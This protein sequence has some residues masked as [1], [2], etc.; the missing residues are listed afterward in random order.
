MDEELS[1]HISADALAVIRAMRQTQDSVDQL[2]LQTAKRFGDMQRAGQSLA[3]M[4]GGL[5]AGVSIGAVVGKLVGVQREFDVLNSSMVTITGSSA[6][7]EQEMR[8]IKEFAAT[9]PFALTEVTQAFVKMKSLGLDAS[10]QSLESY[11][12]TAS[13]MGKNLNQLIEAVADASTGEFERLKEFGIKANTEGNKVSLTFQGVTTTIGKNAAE[14]TGYLQ[15]LG[16]NQFAGAM[17]TRAATLDGAI[18]NLGDT[19]DELF[20][21]VNK[22]NA[23]TLIA[24]SVKLASGALGDA[25]VVL[26]ALNAATVQNA[27]DTGALSTFQ[28]ALG[29]AFETV[30][31]LGLELK[32]VLVQ[33]GRELGALAAQAVAVATLDF[34]QAREIGRLAR[35]DAAQARKDLDVATRNVLMAR[36]RAEELKAVGDAGD[37]VSRRAASAASAAARQ[38]AAA[39]AAAAKAAEAAA[40]AAKNAVKELEEQRKLIAELNGLQ[41]DYLEQLARHAALRAKGA[42]SETEYVKALE[43]LIAK[44]PSS[45]ALTKQQADLEKDRVEALKALAEMERKRTE[46][47]E[48]T[49][50]GLAEQNQ[51][52]REEIELIGLTERAQLSVIQARMDAVILTKE[53]TLAELERASAITGSQTRIEIALAEEIR[54]LRERGELLSQK[55]SRTE[56][57]KVY[58]DLQAEGRRFMEQLEQGL[59]DSLFRAF[60]AGRGFF[61][62][63]WDGI[64]N[65]FKTTVL[66]LAIQGVVGSVLGATGL[67]TAN[68]ASASSGLEGQAVN[69]LISQG[70]QSLLGNVTIAGSSLAAI[71]SSV[72]TG[73]SAGFSGTSVTAAIAAY[74]EAGMAGVASGLGLGASLGTALSTVAMAIPYVA[75]A[76]AVLSAIGAFRSTKQVGYGIAGTLGEGD[77]NDYALNRKSGT[78]F[79]G[80]DYSV[81]M[82]GVAAQSQALQDA[83]NAIRTNVAGMAEQ[84]GIGSDAIKTFTV[85]LGNDLIHPDTGGYGIKLDG[86][87]QDQILAKIEEALVSANEQLAAFAL[88]TTVFTRDG[89]TAVQT[90]GRL[91]GSLGSVNS[92][93]K[94]LGL[95]LADASLAGADAASKFVDSF[96]GAD[97]FAQVASSYY[98]NFYTEAERTAATVQALTEKFGVL[99]LTMPTSRDGLSALI[100]EQQR[101][102][103]A[104]SPVVVE[105]FKLSDT[106]ASV[107]PAAASAAEAIAEAGR[108]FGVINTNAGLRAATEAEATAAADRRDVI[109]GRRAAEQIR[110]AEQQESAQAAAAVA[111]EAATQAAQARTEAEQAMRQAYEAEIRALDEVIAKRDLAVQALETA[112]QRESGVLQQT[113]NTFGDLAGTLRNFVSGLNSLADTPEQS[114]ARLRA[115]FDAT[116]AAALGGDADATRNVPGAGRSF[117]D[118]ASLTAATRVDMLREIARVQV[119]TEG[120]IDFAEAQKTIAEQQLDA[121]NQQVNGLLT[122]DQSVLSVSESIASLQQANEAAVQAESQKAILTAQVSSLITLNK[123]VLSVRDAILGIEQAVADVAISGFGGGEG[124]GGIGSVGGITAAGA[125]GADNIV[126]QAG[127]FVVAKDARGNLVFA[128]VDGAGILQTSTGIDNESVA[129]LLVQSGQDRETLNQSLLGLAAQLDASGAAYLPGSVFAGSDFGVDFRDLA[130]GGFGGNNFTLDANAALKGPTG[131]GT[132]QANQQIA[133]ALGIANANREL[134]DS[135]RDLNYLQE[136]LGLGLGGTSPVTGDELA[137]YRIPGFASGGVH[138]GGLRWVGENGRELEYTPPSRIFSNSQSNALLNLPFLTG[139]NPTG[140]RTSQASS[141]E[142]NAMK[143]ELAEVRQLL[144]RLVAVSEA[145]LPSVAD[146]TAATA[147]V[148]RRTTRNGNALVTTTETP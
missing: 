145:N 16:D 22:G 113:I 148:L 25:T 37:A 41:P 93:F 47:A 140:P 85:R 30:T 51:S 91:S 129:R 132:L 128:N 105:L 17:A 32:H 104:T 96:G 138:E 58:D 67:G 116:I 100:K 35:E 27:Q 147:M 122:V 13:A 119:A 112:F 44:Q 80:P 127:N 108:A 5:F 43:A 131:F 4:F 70:A 95:T 15:K 49:T 74:T 60:E 111:Q 103:G 107:V 81:A 143:A 101:L 71:G 38:E 121:L 2:S 99:G 34:S 142:V 12:N 33:T 65:L 7:A 56:A 52:L 109:A 1:F 146:H 14:I 21:T 88:G 19:W 8:W 23:G 28:Q 29:I 68:A 87:T 120:V 118:A 98:Q 144:S 125:F 48:Q 136:G 57:V 36:Q 106:F 89:E 18:S 61:S 126:A 46:T 139:A 130:N 11:G 133:A 55:L 42:L 40:A 24:D 6:A 83:Y 53:A 75:A 92:V 135:Y 110:A 134:I 20:R 77:I 64:K 82:R 84:L 10:Q 50:A 3:S 54:L 78:L 86:L 69:S 39:K 62:T 114:T 79:S 45:I 59:T 117:I 94:T 76:V 9:T 90:L 115:R 137:Q 72:A 97:Q 73:V 66:K 123:S 102:Q 63:L 26:E 124:A 31:V 141:S